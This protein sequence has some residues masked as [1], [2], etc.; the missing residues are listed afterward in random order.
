MKALVIGASGQLG[1]D[2]CQELNSVNLVP[3]THADIEIADTA[4]IKRAFEKHK[5]D[6]DSVVINTAAFVSTEKCET[7]P[8]RA[9]ILNALG[10]GN[11][12]AA[13]EARGARLV[14]ISTGYVFGD[15]VPLRTTPYTEFDIPKPIR[16][17]V[18]A[19]SKL[20]GEDLVQS[21]CRRYLLV[22]FTGLFGT[23]GARGKGGNFIETILQA[24]RAQKELRVVNDQVC[25]FTYTR[26]AA[27]KIAELLRTDNYGIFHISN[28]GSASW[29]EFAV[30]IL[31]L[32]GLSAPVVPISSAEYGSAAP[33]PAYSVLDNYHLRLLGM[34]DLR[35]WQAALRDYMVSKGHIK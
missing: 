4:S 26:D 31:K 35:T 3:L 1:T 16:L 11:V 17:S 32:A 20:A 19:K 34:D 23:K 33:R 10:A 27:R 21:F 9:F 30:E 29:H 18:Y 15:E 8:D 13:V 22:R 2:L 6:A 5:V 7:E 14:H 25:S 28:K 24:A 12:A